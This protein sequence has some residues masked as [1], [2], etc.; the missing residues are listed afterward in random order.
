MSEI[1][2]ICVL[3]HGDEKKV[4][5]TLYIEEAI[6]LLLSV[7]VDLSYLQHEGPEWNESQILRN[8]AYIIQSD[9]QLTGTVAFTYVD[10]STAGATTGASYETAKVLVSHN[11]DDG[12]VESD[13]GEDIS[14]IGNYFISSKILE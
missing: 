5:I 1:S 2:Y 4:A 11:Q 6:I 7:F 3:L 12:Y 9:V 8:D 14:E 13:E 10:S